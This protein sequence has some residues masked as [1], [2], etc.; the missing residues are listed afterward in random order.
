MIRQA[1]FEGLLKRSSGIKGYL[2]RR[3]SLKMK[4]TEIK[5]PKITRQRTSGDFQGKVAPPNCNPRRIISVIPRMER[6]PNQSTALSPS[7]TGVLGLC[8]SRNTRRRRNVIPV[9]GRLIQNA[10]RQLRCSVS[11]PPTTGPDGY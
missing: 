5:A 2:A 6:L 1:T 9:N 4:N 7:N 8:T 10:H 11:K 3:F